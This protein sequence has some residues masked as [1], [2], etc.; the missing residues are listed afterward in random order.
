MGDSGDTNVRVAVRTRPL[1]SKENGNGEKS[2]I[3]INDE[4]SQLVITDPQT[5][6]GH[7]FAFDILFNT[8]CLQT[9]LWSRIG[10]PI[11]D[12]AFAGFN[13]TIFAYGQTGSGKTWS[14]QG[15]TGDSELCGIIPRMNQN[16]FMR[17]AEN[18][19][20]SPTT[21]FLVTVSYFELY[22]EVIFDLL[23]NSDRRRRPKG[24]LEIKEHPALG[25]YVKGLQEIVVDTE[26]M[27][28]NIIDKG[29]ASRTVAS[30]AMNADSSRSHSV[31]VIKIHQKDDVQ[32]SKNIFAKINLVD[33]AGSERVKST[34]AQG[35][36]LKEGANINKSLSAL[37][38]VINALVEQSTKP[39]TFVPYR[40]S[41]LT[42]VLQES[43]GGNSVTAMLAAL[44]PAAC[45]FEETLS[46]LK[47]ANRA[48][49]IKVKA[50]KNDEASQVSKL[51]D[52]I[53]QLREQLA[54]E[55]ARMAEGRG[56]SSAMISSNNS[57]MD[58]SELEEKHKQQLRELEDAM[59]D[60]WEAK[61]R[62]SAEHEA[63]RLRLA[64][65][66][67]AV[68]KKLREEQE[69]NWVV[70]EKKGDEVLTL[71]H[72]RQVVEKLTPSGGASEGSSLAGY[73]ARSTEWS[74]KL[75][76]IT[77]LEQQSAEQ[78]TGVHVYSRSLVRDC[79]ALTAAAGGKVG[80]SPQKAYQN[81]AA[82]EDGNNI[83]TA[84]C[85]R[86]TMGLWR[87]LRRNAEAVSM[88]V[89]AWT[90]TQDSLLEVLDALHAS[91][92]TSVQQCEAGVNLVEG[93]DA[94]ANEMESISIGGSSLCGDKAGGHSAQDHRALLRGL[95]LLLQ[96]VNSKRAATRT[97]ITTSRSN[98]VDVLA[99]HAQL[100][101]LL[102]S[103]KQAALTL[104]RTLVE[105][106]STHGANSTSDAAELDSILTQF[107]NTL[108]ELD[109]ASGPASNGSDAP[110][111]MPKSAEVGPPVI[112]LLAP[113]KCQVRGSPGSDLAADVDSGFLNGRTGWIAAPSSFDKSAGKYN[114]DDC[115]LEFQLPRPT[116]VKEVHVQG[117]W[118]CLKSAVGE[119]PVPHLAEGQLA[120][121]SSDSAL[122]LPVFS[123]RQANALHA[124]MGQVTLPC[125]INLATCNGEPEQTALALGDVISWTTLLKK[126]DPG[127]F[128]KR[129]PVR[130]L[131]DLF[132][133]LGTVARRDPDVTLFPDLVAA[134]DW[135]A[136]SESKSSKLEYMQ[137]IVAFIAT[138]IG[139]PGQ[140]VT[141]SVNIVTG[142]E[143]GLTNILLQQTAVCV[144][145]FLHRAVHQLDHI[146]STVHI[147]PKGPATE[148]ASG[149]IAL[150]SQSSPLNQAGA[151]AAGSKS[152][153]G[154]KENLHAA[155]TV[156]I[157]PTKVKISVSKNGRDWLPLPADAK[158]CAVREV[159][160]HLKNW[161]DVQIVSLENIQVKALFVRISP[162]EWAVENPGA[163][164]A[165][166]FIPSLRCGIAIERV[167]K[168]QTSAV[169][170]PVNESKMSTPRAGDPAGKDLQRYLQAFQS[171]S[172]APM[173]CIE[174]AIR[175]SEKQR[176][177]KHDENRIFIENLQGNLEEER[178]SWVSERSLLHEQLRSAEEE[179]MQL[180]L[181]AELYIEENMRLS[182]SLL[183]T[184][185]EASKASSTLEQQSKRILALEEDAQQFEVSRQQ[186]L[187]AQQEWEEEKEEVQEQLVVLTEER[188]AARTNEEDLFERLADVTADLEGIQHSY[189]GMTERCNDTQDELIEARDEVESLKQAL[190]AGHDSN[191]QEA[192]E[193]TNLQKMLLEARLRA[194]QVEREC[195]RWQQEVVVNK[196]QYQDLQREYTELKKENTTL[197]VKCV[198]VPSSSVDRPDV[199]G[200]HAH[201]MRATAMALEMEIALERVSK[202]THKPEPEPKPKLKSEPEPEPEIAPTVAAVAVQE[203]E[204]LEQEEAEL[205][206]YSDLDTS[207]HASSVNQVHDFEAETPYA[208][209]SSVPKEADGEESG[210]HSHA[211]A[212]YEE[213]DFE[214]AEEGADYE[215]EGF[216]DL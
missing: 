208:P 7:N 106:S 151:A 47:Y 57:G 79:A 29:M 159:P 91:I 127:K 119:A 71:L 200:E 179:K 172:A 193:I 194:T 104:E 161:T 152:P 201:H 190:S 130:F 157:W 14:M 188:D 53:K 66:Q 167:A 3:N 153:R 35:A 134:A 94:T 45:N 102:T 23:D 12:K 196:E 50:V 131:F 146:K 8:D 87:Q 52:E 147:Q 108:H 18:K 135:A 83:A 78:L 133:L 19:A 1:S 216:E 81:T 115:Y 38:N 214:E 85:D 33:L 185:A 100:R 41:K 132:A 143:T 2:I 116:Y 156:P 58:T 51:N 180:Q 99:L 103:Y 213:E 198:A 61:A 181:D 101:S 105:E 144:Y 22:N 5:K 112:R 67:S 164:S 122:D 9:D 177:R 16:L 36:T 26:A 60:T 176:Q 169:Q 11:M 4:G 96:Q 165:A 117:G 73:T 76:K 65:E 158:I 189:V 124:S 187:R 207:G 82:D 90:P 43:L 46:T 129:P 205:G 154:A 150:M 48:K 174:I 206:T 209:L 183:Q 70:L 118:G 97:S 27:L 84:V 30:T 192:Q 6:E 17:I 92:Q 212:G 137:H 31:F 175:V 59:R 182:Q 178:T 15:A 88:E 110:S 68:A 42:R 111:V 80:G 149:A 211:D 197:L 141:T 186:F 136:T 155:A 184:Q 13:G 109:V 126:Q 121:S 98:A 89:S 54:A 49:A 163:L 44:S 37:G 72:V 93:T 125:G 140:P 107:V 202:Q 32:E 39:K 62:V 120:K 160:L 55:A 86:A 20:N 113:G 173:A 28:Q 74:Q 128:L 191:A 114:P 21:A 215:E 10:L 171:C 145:A 138:C 195:L 34:G 40:N 75:A 64:E 203:A 204:L 95:K 25:V 168:K 24:G 142:A 162:L 139:K 148:G 210:N 69:R 63:E 199:S 123:P 56:S 170:V 77:E 166:A